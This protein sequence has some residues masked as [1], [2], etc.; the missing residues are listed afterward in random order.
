V[1]SIDFVQHA[2]V[3]ALFGHGRVP[4][5]VDFELIK[6]CFHVTEETVPQLIFVNNPHTA[7]FS[8]EPFENIK[9]QHA[10]YIVGAEEV[11]ANCILQARDMLERR[12]YHRMNE[13]MNH[14]LFV[15]H[16]H[17]AQAPGARPLSAVIEICLGSRMA[18]NMKPVD[19]YLLAVL[20]ELKIQILASNRVKGAS[21]AD[22]PESFYGTSNIEAPDVI[23]DAVDL[24]SPVEELLQMENPQEKKKKALKLL[25]DTCATESVMEDMMRNVC[26]SHLEIVGLRLFV[27]LHTF[28]VGGPKLSMEVVNKQETALFP[29]FQGAVENLAALRETAFVES[30]G[31]SK[32]KL[33]RKRTRGANS[34]ESEQIRDQ[35]F[36][37]FYGQ[38]VG[39]S[40]SSSSSSSSSSSLS[41][42]HI[43]SFSLSK[44][45]RDRRASCP[46]FQARS[47]IS[48]LH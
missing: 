29:D 15:S 31:N 46:R 27:Y 36:A 3:A 41:P 17:D 39:V 19:A 23:F 10:T 14:F 37:S 12:L 24:L 25:V 40:F 21:S 4:S 26:E 32:E 42:S 43:F 1:L 22:L 7:F 9:D 2:E 35:N 47:Q 6:E 38:L 34:E 20:T 33:S 30:P 18:Q 8:R 16:L 28:F 48:N 5:I 44:G 45:I 13:K 11:L